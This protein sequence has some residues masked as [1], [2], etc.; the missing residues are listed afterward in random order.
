MYVATAAGI[1]EDTASRWNGL[2]I[3]WLDDK[4]DKPLTPAGNIKRPS[5]A[6]IIGWI[7]TTWKPIPE[8]M[9]HK[10]YLKCGISNK[11]DSDFEG[12]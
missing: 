1:T 2:I 6:I 10:S 8:E 5:I 4:G 9:V 7:K 3:E 11:M 12:F